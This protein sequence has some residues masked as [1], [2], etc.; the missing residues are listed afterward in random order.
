[1][2]SFDRLD[3]AELSTVSWQHVNQAT[4]RRRRG[5]SAAASARVAESQIPA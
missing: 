2:V 3:H 4:S 1:M 5:V